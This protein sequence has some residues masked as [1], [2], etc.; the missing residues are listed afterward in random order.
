MTQESTPTLQK[1]SLHEPSK[2]LQRSRLSSCSAATLLESPAFVIHEN[3]THEKT[4]NTTTRNNTRTLSYEKP[5]QLSSYPTFETLHE[6]TSTPSLLRRL[7]QETTILRNED[8]TNQRNSTI[9]STAQISHPPIH[10]N[11]HIN[12]LDVSTNSVPESPLLTI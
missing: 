10:E 1:N 4:S 3:F 6:E 11:V 2:F 8:N 12:K 5:I 9:L 7:P